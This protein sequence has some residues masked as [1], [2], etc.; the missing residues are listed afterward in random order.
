MQRAIDRLQAGRTSLIV[1]HRLS[2]LR[3]ANR[4]L[5]LDGGRCVGLG[6]HDALLRHCRLY[7]QMWETQQLGEARPQG[8]ELDAPDEAAAPDDLLALV[9]DDATG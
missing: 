5:V 1:A 8:R 2:T 9:D 4:I 3:Q 7:R 6:T